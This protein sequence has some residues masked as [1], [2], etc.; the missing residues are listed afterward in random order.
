MDKK[1]VVLIAAFALSAGLVFA[2]EMK[3][4]APAADTA[5]NQ[6]MNADTTVNNE[7]MNAD[8]NAAVNEEAAPAEDAAPAAEAPAE[9]PK[10]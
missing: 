1:L 4:D 2:Q 10:Y 3:A 9:A 7:E 8:T 6:E 5:T